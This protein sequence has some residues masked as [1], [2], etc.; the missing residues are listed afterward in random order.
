M[1]RA[2]FLLTVMCIVVTVFAQQ[3]QPSLVDPAV[4]IGRLDNGLTYYI[5]H[6]AEPAGQANFYIAQKVGS[7]LEED[8]QRGLAHFL[9]H[10]CFNGTRHFP[11]NSL[12]KYCERIGVKYG[13]NLN[14]YT[15]IDETV[16][17][18]DNVPV[19]TTPSA[20]D[21]CL[22]ILH[23]WANDLLLLDDDINRE[24][25][26]IHEEW[27]TRANAQ[28]RQI[29]KM[30][31]VVYPNGNR[32]GLRMPIG[33]MEVIDHFP[34]QLLRDYYHKWYRPDLQGIVVVGDIDVDA[35]EKKI[36]DIF[37]PIVLP[38]NPAERVYFEVPD[39]EEP[40]ICM[41]RDKEQPY[42]MTMI[43]CKHDVFPHQKRNSF[44]YYVYNYALDIAAEMVN[45]RIAEMAQ[46]PN[47]PF[48]KAVI[49]DDDFYL[50]RTKRAWCGQ[51]ISSTEGFG[52]A[53]TT[54]YREMLRVVR[55]GFT[56]S[57][58]E[59][60]KANLISAKEDAY[61]AREK[62]KSA[63]YC[64]EYVRHFIDNEP[65]PSAEQDLA[66]TQQVSA[67]VTVEMINGMMKELVGKGNLV[68]ASMLPDKE[69]V[70]F[71]TEKELAEMMAAVE[72][73]DIQ[74]YVD[75]VSNEPLMTELP[76]PGRVVKSGT[77][78]LG[79]KQFVLSNGATVYFRQTDFNQNEVLMK[80]SSRGGTSLYPLSQIAQL[81]ALNSVIELGG[82]SKFSRTDLMKILAGKKVKLSP[83]INIFSESVNCSSTPKDLETMFQLNYLAFTDLR[84]DHDAF[85]SWKER[86]RAII[87]N[88][89]SNPMAAI[90]DSIKSTI[91][92]SPARMSEITLEE[93][94]QLN[95][96]E[97]MRI[98]RER[99]ANAA[100]YTFVI[101]GA[102]DEATIVPLIEQ[103][104]ASLPAGGKREKPN[105][106]AIK[107]K[108]KSLKNV[109]NKKMEVPM[110]TNV[111]F[112]YGK[113]A[114]YNLKNALSFDL[115]LSSL[116]VVLLEEIREKESGTYGIS[117][118]G[119]I[120]GTPY[121]VQQAYMQ[122]F[123]QTSPDRYEYLNQKVRDLV[124][125]FVKE[126]PSEENLEKGKA[127]MQKEHLENLRENNYCQEALCQLL[128]SRVDI[129]DNYESTL[130]SITKEDVRR[131]LESLMKQKVHSEIIMIGEK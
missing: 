23:D 28:I 34:S 35:V 58:Y 101:T 66:L 8:N 31:P 53:V 89:A 115:A 5:R 98:A 72:A 19:A 87:V 49:G 93:L 86:Q 129:T 79:Y 47:P 119:E 16:Y 50:A 33:T 67:A 15:S 104:I 126:G 73:E 123:Y 90:R 42:P 103:Y 124:S 37:G 43:F 120:S 74:P 1:K 56:L 39:N 83:T 71:P 41:T 30:L 54:L 75:A 64:S 92:T 114:K 112:D 40:I 96:D 57:E 52:E 84:Q 82:L 24:R 14:A 68:V 11:G 55:C 110:V 94:D 102:V 26:V 122:I 17:N 78:K 27:R 51:V 12:V 111:F 77:A 128:E 20:L 65:I 29:E 7:I 125:Q 76:Q 100:D 85:Q 59:R 118:Y 95:Y 131:A 88:R 62:K 6:N 32:Y 63:D 121:P 18:I 108:D 130:Q 21:S 97:I 127:F 106:N 60:A 70:T 13:E 9:E 99:F 3:S 22:W 109:F 61:H 44:D 10:M 81:K 45:A 107:Y 105:L 116:E 2:I 80:A 38:E 113:K 25:G 91:F 48:V 46:R 117:A 36:K 69:G 4:R